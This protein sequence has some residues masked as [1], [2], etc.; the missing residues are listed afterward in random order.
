[1]KN[2]QPHNKAE[3]GTNDSANNTPLADVKDGTKG[4]RR[5]ITGDRNQ[6]PACGEF[7]N[8]IAAFDHH[9][10]G[11][12][13]VDRRCRTSADMRAMGMAVNHAGFWITK[14][15]P[16]KSLSGHSATANQAISHPGLYGHINEPQKTAK[17]V[18]GRR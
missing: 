12:F 14:P 9:R 18:W 1:M 5:R 8:S 6:C 7:F 15:M 11:K 10:T 17:T 3:L 16:Q 4:E 13:G 2:A